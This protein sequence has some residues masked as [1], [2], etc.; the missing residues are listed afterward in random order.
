MVLVGELFVALWLLAVSGPATATIPVSAGGGTAPGGG[1]GPA[2]SG[3]GS[4]TQPDTNGDDGGGNQGPSPEELRSAE[5]TCRDAESAVERACLSFEEASRESDPARLRAARA[6]YEQALSSRQRAERALSGLTAA[7]A[8]EEETSANAAEVVGR[9]TGEGRSG[10]AGDPV[11]VSSGR[12]IHPVTEFSYAYFGVNLSLSRVYDA[13]IHTRGAFGPQ[14]VSSMDTRI[15]RGVP[16]GAPAYAEVVRGFL[17]EISA[18]RAALSVEVAAAWDDSEVIESA[19]SGAAALTGRLRELLAPAE[20]ARSAAARAVGAALQ[21]HRADLASRAT[22][23]ATRCARLY[24]DIR[25]SLSAAERHCNEL[26]EIQLSSAFLN[27]AQE[28]AAESVRAA[29][30]ALKVSTAHHR[31]NG[32]VRAYGDN[33]ALSAA[34]ADTVTLID[35]RGIPHLY[36]TSRQ[37]SATGTA[38]PG[39]LISNTYPEGAEFLPVAKGS[40]TSLVRDADQPQISATEDQIYLLSDGSF[41]RLCPD[42]SLWSYSRYGQLS[43][44][45]D[46]N[47]NS[48]RCV[49]DAVG[50]LVSLRDQSGRATGFVWKDRHVVRLVDPCGAAVCFAYD[51]SGCLESATGR[52]G[53]TVTY[54]YHDGRLNRITKPDGTQRV[55]LSARDAAGRLTVTVT[56]EAGNRE[57]FVHDAAHHRF[58]YVN[59]E[60]A[61]RVYSYNEQGSVTSITYPD[62]SSTCFDYD[63]AGYLLCHTNEIGARTS[64]RYDRAGRLVA[65]SDPAGYTRR[66]EYG[67]GVSP[68]RVTRFTDRRG[69][70]TRFTYDARGNLIEVRYAD[71]AREV[72]RRGNQGE[73]L[74]RVDPEG[75]SFKFSYGARGYVKEVNL[76]GPG[77]VRIQR[78]AMGRMTSYSDAD[79][80]MQRYCWTPDG[81]LAAVTD[82][83]GNRTTC[84]YNQRRD[85]EEVQE[86][87]GARTVYQY[88][89]R[90]LLTERVDAAGGV[91]RWTRRADG[92][93]SS[94]RTPSGRVFGYAYDTR[95][96]PSAVGLEGSPV[97]HRL[98]YDVAGRLVS[99]MDPDGNKTCFTYGPRA[100]LRLITHGDGTEERFA[101]DACGNL[102]RYQDET[103]AVSRWS[104]D[105][106][107]RV[108]SATDP[109]GGVTGYAYDRVG[110]V[111]SVTDPCRAVTRFAYGNGENPVEKR[112]A[113]GYLWTYRWTPAGR[114]SSVKDPEGG[115]IRYEYDARGKCERITDPLGAVRTVSYDA[116]GLVSSVTGPRGARTALSRDECG[117]ILC[118]TDPYGN[119]TCYEYD[120]AGRPVKATDPTGAVWEQEYDEAGRRVIIHDPAGA[121]TRRS[122]DACGRLAAVVDAEGRET[123]YGYDSRGRLSSVTDPAGARW[124]WCYDGAGRVTSETDPEGRIH[125]YGYDRAGR[126]FEEVDRLGSRATYEYDEAG[127]LTQRRDFDGRETTCSYDTRGNLVSVTTGTESESRFCLDSRGWLT[128][129]DNA[130][131]RYRYDYDAAGNIVRQREL[132]GGSDLRFE[133]DACGNRTRI[134]DLSGGLKVRFSYGE[135]GELTR[136][137]LPGREVTT[138]SYDQLLRQR[139]VRRSNGV[140]TRTGYDPCGRVA[141]VVHRTTGNSGRGGAV[142]GTA[143][144]YA[145]DGRRIGAVDQDGKTTLY[146]YDEAG[147]LAAVHYPLSCGKPEADRAMMARLEI[148]DVPSALDPPGKGGTLPT[149][150]RLISISPEVEDALGNAAVALF[151]SRKRR[152]G[153]SL[154]AWTERFSYDTRGNMVRRE[155]PWGVVSAAYDAE[156][157]M[158]ALGGLRY[159]YDASGNPLAIE[160]AATRIGFTH[161]TPALLE[162]VVSRGDRR[163][164][165][166]SYTYDA[167]GRRAGAT[168]REHGIRSETTQ[169]TRVTYDLFSLEPVLKEITGTGSGPAPSSAGK[170]QQTPP[171]RF[172]SNALSRTPA[173]RGA[174]DRRLRSSV[175][176]LQLHLGGRLF[177][178]TGAAGSR[179]FGH[180]G[181]G[182]LTCSFDT[183]GELQS[184]WGYDALGTPLA[185][186]DGGTGEAFMFAGA[187]YDPG[188]RGYRVGY[189]DYDPAAGRFLTA[190]PARVGVNWYLYGGG[191]AV[192]W[193]EES[194]FAPRN[195]SEEQ[196]TRY[197]AALA[198]WASDDNR[199][200][201]YAPESGDAWRAGEQWDCADVA[202]YLATISMAAANKGPSILPDLADLAGGPL[203]DIRNINSAAFQSEDLGNISFYRNRDGTIDRA[204]NSP[205]VEVG[206]IGVFDNH[207]IT[208][209]DVLRDSMGNVTNIET[210]QGHF[211]G[212]VDRVPIVS[213]GDL[214]SYK[215]T[216]V[217]WGE[218]G[219]NSAGPHGKRTNE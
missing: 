85:L 193:F 188:T 10:T 75:R 180:D 126:L 92:K 90:H 165:E 207:I 127:R 21:V 72:F 5:Q 116:R 163:T 11:M 119:N 7:A 12:F 213:Q 83:D 66:W 60:G 94:R 186:G 175:R 154:E 178:S 3:A 40:G 147:R 86:P 33:A 103:G 150:L 144:A 2:D 117:R 114:L 99:Y 181:R 45:T 108:L 15:I 61:Q 216:F 81:L 205:H 194:G 71:G 58:T 109:G 48:I 134:S 183:Q 187:P 121:E 124:R 140:E 38:L 6:A 128:A 32:R 13:G 26:R 77:R 98:T 105:S 185:P 34:G 59:A 14:W 143:Y 168:Y 25:D 133:Y 53:H 23:A 160:G 139:S 203:E 172:H 184:A 42:G 78:D 120:A 96:M 141:G 217:G 102:V 91:T 137:I 198:V 212:D 210:I 132:S 111:I 36:R 74:E 35:R 209:T 107:N 4:V 24:E 155:T 80:V 20:D 95:G 88:D 73:L 110:R 46:Q 164:A 190:D 51:A 82:A 179:Y 97:T 204:W 8:R 41:R 18:A 16:A 39:E 208:V 50:R 67:S 112:D 158:T 27:R 201:R 146:E 122:Y 182:S 69:N 52:A 30:E 189:R 28:R 63:R 219:R 55:V 125:R 145:A 211:R 214:D 142:L 76:P 43:A 113:G 206:T 56:D 54:G 156:N 89:A 191:D 31:L 64:Y 148:R 135:M 170:A 93:V 200:P 68:A 57:R 192:N 138:F 152:P 151:G 196:R 131:A 167:F 199:I 101:Y 100:L 195:L 197:K 162:R 176:S 37:P 115:V 65:C 215:G 118:V 174:D 159:R 157:R 47:G 87:G 22:R 62:G 84:R 218:I 106:R 49:R 202:T 153:R 79:G 161:K 130:S 9:L 166:S 129:A 169:A 177:A 29:E 136:L 1:P 19:L 173:F 17:A 171:A 70:Q 44:V 149:G 123:S 104:Y